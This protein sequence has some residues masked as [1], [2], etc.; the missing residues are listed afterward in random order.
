MNVCCS[1]CVYVSVPYFS[2]S[3]CVYVCVCRCV[4]KWV[5]VYSTH[6]GPVLSGS[7]GLLQTQACVTQLLEAEVEAVAAH[8]VGSSLVPGRL[9]VDYAAAL[10]AG[11]MRLILQGLAL[12][13]TLLHHL[14]EWTVRE[15][16]IQPAMCRANMSPQ[17]IHRLNIGNIYSCRANIQYK[18]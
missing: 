10:L 16:S 2:M 5:C 17:G 15:R 8:L 13:M 9:H 1:V 7:R 3:V 4:Y 14:G 18:H 12:S 11:R 6:H